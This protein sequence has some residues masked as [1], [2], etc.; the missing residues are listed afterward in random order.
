V[1]HWTE[2]IK[3]VIER[4][5]NED[6]VTWEEAHPG[7]GKRVSSRIAKSRRRALAMAKRETKASYLEMSKVTG[8]D[9]TTLVKAVQQAIAKKE[10][11]DE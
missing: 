9:H 8:L 4:E 11:P 5:L 10:V 3:V 7:R 1:I 2:R 6:G